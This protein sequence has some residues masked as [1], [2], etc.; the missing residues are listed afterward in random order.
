MD[1]AK[2]ILKVCFLGISTVGK[3][4][5][6]QRYI[7]DYFE[8]TV[9]TCGVNYLSKSYSQKDNLNREYEFYFWDTAGQERFSQMPRLVIKGVVGVIVVYD[10]TNSISFEFAKNLIEEL[11]QNEGNGDIEILLLGNKLDL[12]PNSN[13]SQT[14]SIQST[15]IQIPQNTTEFIKKHHIIY[16]QVS[17]KTGININDSIDQLCRQVYEKFKSNDKEV[18]IRL[19]EQTNINKKCCN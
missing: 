5:I 15:F 19:R 16:Y 11:I 8:D 7:N 10:L 17:A 12:I 2:V 18:T 6:L 4:S 3:T 1:K 14:D 13:Q 9:G